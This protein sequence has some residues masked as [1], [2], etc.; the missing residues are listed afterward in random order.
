MARLLLEIDGKIVDLTP[1][2]ERHVCNLRHEVEEDRTERLLLK[3]AMTMK[4]GLA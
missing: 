2:P 4:A 1:A 3:L